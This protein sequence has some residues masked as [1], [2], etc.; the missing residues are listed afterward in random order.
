MLT[1]WRSHNGQLRLCQQCFPK[2][3]LPEAAVADLN[4]ALRMLDTFASVGARSFVVTKIDINKKL[5]WGKTYAPVELREKL[6]AMMRTAAVE[7]PY[8]TPDDQAI[9]AGETSSCALPAL[10]LNS[11]RS[12]MSTMLHC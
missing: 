12:T 4:Q 5:L 3:R 6:P 11:F 1:E 7:K 9:D 2:D 8:R 10:R